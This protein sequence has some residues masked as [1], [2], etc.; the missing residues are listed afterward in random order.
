MEP[1]VLRLS[2]IISQTLILLTPWLSRSFLLA[3]EVHHAADDD[4]P[5]KRLPMQAS[6]LH[7][8]GVIVVDRLASVRALASGGAREADT[9][10]LSPV[11][12]T[13]TA[14]VGGSRGGRRLSSGGDGLDRA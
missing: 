3:V 11:S 9:T 6:D 13:S 12:S 7:A 5:I 10:A 2:I 8:L 14:G 4:W 1:S